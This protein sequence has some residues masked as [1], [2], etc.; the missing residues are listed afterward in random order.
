MHFIRKRKIMENE[1]NISSEKNTMSRE[2]FVNMDTSKPLT[3]HMN[4]ISEQDDDE[5][6]VDNT[7][8]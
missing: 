7:Q 8:D 2:L 1:K 4:E 6:P 5:E 3:E